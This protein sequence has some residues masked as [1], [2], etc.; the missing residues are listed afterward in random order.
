MSSTKPPTYP[1]N[2][3]LDTTPVLVV[4]AGEVALRKVRGLLAAG[5]RVTV[6]APEVHPELV[7]LARDKQI[8]LQRRPYPTGLAMEYRLVF[9][10]TGDEKVDW[11]VSYDA[12]TVGIFVNVADVPEQCS[13]YLPAVVRRGHLQLA[14]SS[15]GGA[16]FA[17]RRLRKRL[18]AQFGESYRQWLDSAAVFRAAV[19]ESGL[20]PEQQEQLFDRFFNETLPP[21]PESGQPT[22]LDET[23]WRGW[24]QANQADSGHEGEADG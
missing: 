21:A 7:A 8:E 19:L 14:V 24:I 22:V 13:F 2:L 1:V 23:T 5:A 11:L 12:A 15:D 17:A 20:S 4:G 6:V 18:E 9:A 16:P 10:A 3:C